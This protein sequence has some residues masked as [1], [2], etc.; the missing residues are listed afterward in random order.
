MFCPAAQPAQPSQPSP[1]QPSHSR[2]GYLHIMS[3]NEAA[4]DH[5]DLPHQ[6]QKH[7][8]HRFATQTL[9]IMLR[10]LR[11]LWGRCSVLQKY[12]VMF[13]NILEK[14]EYQILLALTPQV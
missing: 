11:L 10:L 13:R 2:L 5:T 14:A 7:S 3:A 6:P 9:H 1:A 8:I 12:F 4:A